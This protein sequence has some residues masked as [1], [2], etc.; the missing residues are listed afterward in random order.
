MFVEREFARE[1]S[2]VADDV[3]TLLD[4]RPVFE[5]ADGEPHIRRHTL[6]G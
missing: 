3:P 6:L 2:R 1:I 5:F 4:V